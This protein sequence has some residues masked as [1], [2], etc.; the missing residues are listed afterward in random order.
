MNRSFKSWIVA[1]AGLAGAL[2]VGLFCGSPAAVAEAKAGY[3]PRPKGTVTFT[4]DVAPI[5][6]NNCTSCHRPGEVAPFTL[7]N[8]QDVKK[9]AAQIASVTQSSYM[10]PWSAASHGE[11]ENERI[12]SADQKGLLKQWVEEGT[13]EGAK[14]DLPALP[15]YTPGWQLGEPDMIYEPKESYTLAAEGDDVFRCFVMPTS[16]GEDKYVA[17]MEVRPANRKVVHHIIAYLDQ[18]HS[19]R[20]REERTKDGQIG[21]NGSPGVGTDGWLGAWAPGYI[22]R[23]APDGVGTLLPK[24]VDIVM[25]VHYHKDGKVEKDKTRIGVYFCKKPVDKRLRLLPIFAPLNIPAGAEDYVTKSIQMPVPTDATVLSVAP[26]M[27]LLGKQMDVFAILPDGT[28]KSLVNVPNYDY[29]WQ[30]SYTYKEPVKIP[31]GSKVALV[32]HYDNSTRNLKNPNSPPKPVGWGEQTTDEMCIGFVSY[33]MDSEH[34][35]KGQ[36][37]EDYLE[38]LMKGMGNRRKANKSSEAKSDG[39]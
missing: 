37:K 16:F 29:N 31:S 34:I 21:F 5:V 28:K 36:A 14:K 35:T 18:S 22:P 9:R 15:I 19:N 33:T 20:G 39:K 12:L 23:P 24:G 26:H 7:M 27:H 30:T 17:A 10:P 11:F 3:T 1:T 13:K 6:F 38:K 25:Q 4:K 8:Y 32:A 2:A